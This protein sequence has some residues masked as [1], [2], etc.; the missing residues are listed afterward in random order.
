MSTMFSWIRDR[1]R[2][3]RQQIPAPDRL[4]LLLHVWRGAIERD[5]SRMAAR[6]WEALRD[7]ATAAKAADVLA[8]MALVDRH[9]LSGG[10]WSSASTTLQFAVARFAAGGDPAISA[11]FVIQDLA[12]A[13][14]TNFRTT[15][16]PEYLAKLRA[17]RAAAE[18][19]GFHDIR[20]GADALLRDYERLMLWQAEVVRRD[21]ASDER[22]FEQLSRDH[23]AR[24]IALTAAVWADPRDPDRRDRK[25]T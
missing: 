5:D 1:F 8:A 20:D 3:P 22:T 16:I 2:G 24:I 21:A 6:A 10:E 4:R 7:D 17:I 19:T 13:A 15:R 18:R 12:M 11:R 14:A 23:D 9:R 25:A